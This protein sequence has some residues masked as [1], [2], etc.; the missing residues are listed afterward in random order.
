MRDTVLWRK[1]SRI[2]MKLADTLQID[3]EKALDLFYSTR[4][5]LQLSDPKYGLQL[6][7]DDYIL[8]DLME[9]II[10]KEQASLTHNSDKSEL[11]RNLK[12]T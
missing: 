9:E 7:S 11:A 3:P 10:S 2:I 1:Q 12:R 6:M 5:Y 4:I 8:E